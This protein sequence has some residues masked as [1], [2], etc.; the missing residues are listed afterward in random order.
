MQI[1][2]E[3][4]PISKELDFAKQVYGATPEEI[5]SEHTE[6]LSQY[7]EYVLKELVKSVLPELATEVPPAY[8]E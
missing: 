1:K 3:V 6:L 8:L 7:T 2:R 5:I 4:T